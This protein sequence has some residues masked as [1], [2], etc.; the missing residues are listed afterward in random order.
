MTLEELLAVDLR[1][2]PDRH[3][4]E[5]SLAEIQGK[6]QEGWRGFRSGNTFIMNKPDKN[7]YLEFHCYNADHSEQ[8]AKNVLKF[9]GEAK[10][11]GF[12]VAWTPYKN[13]KINGLFKSFIKDDCLDITEIQDGYLAKVR[14]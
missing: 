9:F 1:S 10:E 6:M 14:L 5:E 11:S 7:G 4:A 2:H 12:K 3:S 8:L 13:P